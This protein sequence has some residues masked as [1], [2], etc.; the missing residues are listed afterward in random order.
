M[1]DPYNL[2]RFVEAQDPI[3]EAVLE[4]LRS[5]LKT[6]HWMWFVFP[7]IAGL[8]F[9]SMARRFEIA[10]VEEA[11]AYLEH[12]ILGPRLRECTRLVSNIEGRTVRQIFGQ[13]DDLK[14]RSSMTLFAKVARDDQIF[15]AALAKYGG[16]EHDPLTLGILG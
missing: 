10:S 15:E 3:Y 13:P 1:D 5:G 7:Q 8:G 14:F 11:G 2:R 12:P 9:S 6:G 16:G 4:E